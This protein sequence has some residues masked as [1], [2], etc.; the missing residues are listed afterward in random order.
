MGVSLILIQ[1]V[2]NGLWSQVAVSL[3]T[4]MSIVQQAMTLM[5]SC[6]VLTWP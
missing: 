4:Q 6:Q 1:F 2:T 3:H 5:Q